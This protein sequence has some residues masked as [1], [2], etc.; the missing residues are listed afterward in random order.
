MTL[1]ARNIA[2]LASRK[3]QF[4]THLTRLEFVRAEGMELPAGVCGR[5]QG[6]AMVYDQVDWYDTIFARG[7]LDKSITERVFARKVNV[8]A[9][10]IK[11]VRCHVGVVSDAR[12]I[13]DSVVVTIDLLDTAD[14][15]VMLEY[16]RACVA[17]DIE[18]GLSIGFIPRRGEMVKDPAGIATGQYRFLEIEWRE[19]SVTPVPAVPGTMVT[20]ARNEDGEPGTEDELTADEIR[21]ILSTAP[22]DRLN[23]VLIE[24]GYA[25]STDNA[26][27]DTPDADATPPEDTPVAESSNEEADEEVRFMPFE[28]RIAALRAS[29]ATSTL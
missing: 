14:G 15:R 4:T 9:D 10:H 27:S 20:G 1:T 16:A 29:F 23:E 19:T 2:D 7:C 28:E 24:M 8:F 6:I 11:Q 3:K 22:Q 12:T 25:R 18:T 21:A 13:G 5:M 26:A 17:A